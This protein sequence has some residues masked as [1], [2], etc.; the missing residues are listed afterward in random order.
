[1]SS[2][3]RAESAPALDDVRLNPDI[4][5]V[6]GS[7]GMDPLLTS[8]VAGLA[9]NPQLLAAAVL[10][11]DPQLPDL[12]WGNMRPDETPQVPRVVNV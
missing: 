1:M 8:A 6:A 9:P 2:K 4:P 5:A 10:K 3:A 11:P 7:A 12:L